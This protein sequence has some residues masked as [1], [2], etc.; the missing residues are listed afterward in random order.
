MD[1][2]DLMRGVHLAGNGCGCVAHYLAAF[3]DESMAW[4]AGHTTLWAQN[5]LGPVRLDFRRVGMAPRGMGGQPAGEEKLTRL[6]WLS[7]AAYPCRY[8]KG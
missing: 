1:M 2:V 7:A 8:S 4:I 3:M 6:C 5:L